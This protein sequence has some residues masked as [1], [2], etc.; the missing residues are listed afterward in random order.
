MQTAEIESTREW[1]GAT[2]KRR[3]RH[4]MVRHMWNEESLS[5]CIINIVK[6]TEEAFSAYFMQPNH[7]LKL[8]RRYESLVFL[9]L[10]LNFNSSCLEF[11]KRHS[12]TSAQTKPHNRSRSWMPHAAQNHEKIFAFFLLEQK[13]KTKSTQNRLLMFYLYSVGIRYCLGFVCVFAFNFFHWIVFA[14]VT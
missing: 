4:C 11:S 2:S 10:S 3:I 13:R 14:N 6:R 1:A 8:L 7:F 9:S 12:H 5:L